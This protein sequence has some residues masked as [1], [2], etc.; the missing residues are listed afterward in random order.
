MAEVVDFKFKNKEELEAFL[1]PE[2]M[3]EIV[4]YLTRRGFLY[5]FDVEENNFLPETIHALYPGVTVSYNPH[6]HIYPLFLNF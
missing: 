3:A 4:M 1:T 2:K 5:R 6:S